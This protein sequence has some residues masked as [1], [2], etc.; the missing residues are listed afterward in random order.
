MKTIS[1]FVEQISQYLDAAYPMLAIKTHE[2]SRICGELEQLRELDD[3]RPV[4][5]WSQTLGFTGD[6]KAGEKQGQK[7]IETV[8]NMPK[9]SVVVFKD[10]HGFLGNALIIR[11]L[12][13]MI[14]HL[15][16]QSKMIV[17]LS[18]VV[19][20]PIELEK[21]IQ[22]VTYGLPGKQDLGHI[23]D[24]LVA[25][26]EIATKEK[27]TVTQKS[28]VLDAAKSLTA[29]E[30]KNAF[31]LALSKHSAFEEPAIRTVLNEKAQALKKTN[32]MSWVDN[33][34]SLDQI[35][36][37]AKLK[38]YIEMIA[39]IFLD[40]D[41]ALKYGM[42]EED[43]PRSIAIVGMPGCGKSM[44]AKAIAKVLRTGLVQTDFGRIFSAGEGKV[45]AA[46]N[47]IQRRNELIEAMAPCIDWWDE[48]EK[49]LAGVKGSDQNP[50]EARV[51]ATLLTWF[52]EFRARI[53]VTA[54]INR[55]EALP[56]EMISRFQKVFFVDLPHQQ[57]REEIIGL[58]CS[59]RKLELDEN[60]WAAMARQM[61]GFSGR[62]IRNAVQA[63]M[64]MG[65]ATK[66]KCDDELIL[67]A[68]SR[69]TPLSKSR[70]EDLANIRA[71]AEKNKVE[72]A[73]EPESTDTGKRE[74]KVKLRG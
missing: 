34:L 42:L 13:D 40:P 30:A 6:F 17:F 58:L 73:S 10:F 57:E 24:T 31:A 15:E 27:I 49:G 2:E 35:G 54:T 33:I 45:G 63:A 48:A 62:E 70:S 14:P 25:E 37:L 3:P 26:T 61:V 12:R 5:F 74:R 52:E 71:W 22:L 50:W 53:L 55:Q 72:S 44:T 43:F 69:I 47:N 18:P 4:S 46:E 23:F 16:E 19:S 8:V 60:D 28:A 65:F 51:G 32:L 56:P 36:G 64:Q 39:P 38:A 1:T 9:Q 67:E 68:A 20:I 59:A 29:S 21:D 66:K 41:G 7:A 11:L